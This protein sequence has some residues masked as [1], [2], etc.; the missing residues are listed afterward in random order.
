MPESHQWKESLPIVSEPLENMNRIA[1]AGIVAVIRAESPQQ[2]LRIT[3]AVKAGGVAAV[4]ITM[5]VPGALDVIRKLAATYRRGEVLVG[6]G[7][8]LNSE[9]ARACLSAGAE[10]IVS[11]GTDIE[12]IR[13][14]HRYQKLVIPGVATPTELMRAMEAGAAVC[15]V[16][17]ASLFGPKIISA[18]RGPFPQA[19]L[20]PTGGV[21]V[22][23]VAEW[24]KAG[25]FAVGVGSELTAGAGSG[26]YGAVTRVAKDFL[27]RIERARAEMIGGR[28]D[29]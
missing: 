17:P 6:A 10:Y 2:A 12:T 8:V 18:L 29:D 23:N 21:N 20:L 13:L 28:Q 26:D 14:C 15:K 4:E 3:E 9:T 27:T 1:T 22:N 25:S 5:T 19:R 7:T 24:I 16:F 11:P